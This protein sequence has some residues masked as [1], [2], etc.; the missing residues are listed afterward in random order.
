MKFRQRIAWLMVLFFL[1]GSFSVLYYLFEFS[2]HYNQFALEHVN[3]YHNPNEA[4][5]VKNQKGEKAKPV[6]N[7]R[8]EVTG[9]S[10]AW[11]HFIDVPVAVW[12]VVFLLPYLQIFFMILACT[13]AEPKM[14]M[15]F[16]WPCL[17]YLKY[18]QCVK[19]PSDKPYSMG[20]NSTVQTNG[21]MVFNT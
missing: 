9:T 19:G 5:P 1:G 14:S 20:L 7:E 10:S 18:Q 12:F 11:H 6:D 21:H 16:Q 8:G 4:D 3:A 2:E 17:I 15:A 13:K